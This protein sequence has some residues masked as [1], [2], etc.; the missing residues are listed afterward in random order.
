MTDK[1]RWIEWNG[2]DILRCEKTHHHFAWITR[3]QYPDLGYKV[4]L[5]DDYKGPQGDWVEIAIVPD[6][7]TAKMIAK[8]NVEGELV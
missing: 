6:L 3:Y 5:W 4:Q 1:M 2:S 7:D 8:L